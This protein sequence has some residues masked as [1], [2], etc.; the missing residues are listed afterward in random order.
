MSPEHQWQTAI[1]WVQSNRT[2]VGL[3]A[4]PY[5]RYMA[6][7]PKDVEQEAILAAFCVL[8]VLADQSQDSSKFGAY[9]RVQFRSRC[10]KMATGGMIG[11]MDDTGQIAFI[12]SEQKNNELEHETMEHALQKMSNRQRQISRWI[13]AQPTPVSTTCI[14]KKFGICGRTVREIL[15]NA[16]RRIEKNNNGNSQLRKDISAAA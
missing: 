9:F 10:I 12:P 16:I 14:A 6:S 4:A 7:T 11:S 13:L 8:D 1:S 2:L 5:R 3:I 15:S